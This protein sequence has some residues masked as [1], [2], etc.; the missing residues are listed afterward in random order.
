MIWWIITLFLLALTVLGIIYDNK[1]KS[2]VVC[3]VAVPFFIMLAIAFIVTLVHTYMVH[4][5]HTNLVRIREDIKVFEEKYEDQ[6]TL[7][8]QNVKEYPMEEG[9]MK[10]FDPAILLK[11]PE[12]KS[13]QL[14]M[15]TINLTISIQDKIFEKKLEYN[16]LNQR[17]RFHSNRWLSATLM[18]PKMERLVDEHSN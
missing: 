6:K 18:K 4:G 16:S 1:K 9:L 2:D 15:E 17:L 5:Y 11:L 14:L 7:I 12:I 13:N 10:N 3:I 8:I